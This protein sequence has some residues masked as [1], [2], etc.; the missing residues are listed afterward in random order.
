M[1]CREDLHMMHQDQLAIKHSL[2]VLLALMD[3]LYQWRICCLMDLQHH[4]LAVEVDMRLCI[5]G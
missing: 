5:E 3:M 1:T 2:E 4:L